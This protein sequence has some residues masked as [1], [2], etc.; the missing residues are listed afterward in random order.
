MPYNTRRKSLS[1]SEL[2]IVVPKRQRAATTHPSKDAAD[3]PAAKK[4]RCSPSPLSSPPLTANASKTLSHK[5]SPHLEH[6]KKPSKA[7]LDTPPSSPK[8]GPY[9]KIDTEGIRDEIVVAVIKQLEATA[10][11]PQTSKE[12]AAA[13]ASSVSTITS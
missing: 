13:L 1:L 10:N 2:G 7:L 3:E 9:A 5:L 11:R 12:L 4:P 6:D 8:L